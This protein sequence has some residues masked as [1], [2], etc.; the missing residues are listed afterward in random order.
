MLLQG[1]RFLLSTCLLI[2]VWGGCLGPRPMM[3]ILSSNLK[4][5]E[6]LTLVWRPGERLLQHRQKGFLIARHDYF[7]FH[8]AFAPSLAKEEAGQDEDGEAEDADQVGKE[9]PEE[10][11]FRGCVCWP[12]LNGPF[13]R[14]RD[15]DHVN[16]HQCP[17]YERRVITATGEVRLLCFYWQYSGWAGPDPVQQDADHDQIGSSAK[18]K[19]RCAE[20]VATGWWLG[21]QMGAKNGLAGMCKEGSNS[22]LPPGTGWHLKN[23]TRPGQKTFQSDP[24]GFVDQE[25]LQIEA[26]QRLDLTKLQGH[27][28]SPK[29]PKCAGYFGHFCTLLHLEYLQEVATLR[30]RASRRSGEELERG[31]WA[32]LG[33]RVRDVAERPAKGKGGKGAGKAQTSSF[34]MTLW[35]PP[36]TDIDK[37]RFRKGDSII[38]SATHPLQDRFAEGQLQD[39]TDK[40]ASLSFDG[41]RP[42]QDCKQR[43]W[44]L[45]KGS[46]RLSYVRQ[47]DSLVSLCTGYVDNAVIGEDC[48]KIFQ[49]ITNGKVGQCDFWA[50]QVWSERE[51]EQQVERTIPETLEQRTAS[52]DVKREAGEAAASDMSASELGLKPGDIVT[53]QGLKSEELNNQQ[54]EVVL[55]DGG[56]IHVN[57]QTNQVEE[58]RINVKVNGSIKAIR[59]SNLKR[60]EDRP[61]EPATKPTAAVAVLAAEQSTHHSEMMAQCLEGL[62]SC[63]DSQ[64]QAVAA[65]LQRRFTIV[66]GPPG[67]GQSEPSAGL[68][69]AH[70]CAP[71][72]VAQR[73]SEVDV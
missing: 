67:T 27:V 35:L 37:L 16:Q 23:L 46:N 33:L 38:L 47:L 29:G 55:V 54:G 60:L 58:E 62:S 24:A 9:W 52:T 31:G 12:E 6:V 51:N 50:S 66:Q 26:L 45:D 1:N 39:L 72:W 36:K 14:T 28:V 70:A 20:P 40:W 2:K 68:K 7:G 65:A 19:R 21:S 73:I 44:R 64:H 8:S 61:M 17:T 25:R 56:I 30:R 43:R 71:V 13:R 41:V 15:F 63:T 34:Q 42:P 32:L 11:V 59:I 53:L 22:E 57:E 18:K 3:L 10:L 5:H 4:M 49:I 48:C 69:S